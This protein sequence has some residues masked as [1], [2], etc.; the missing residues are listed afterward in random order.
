MHSSILELIDPLRGGKGYVQ[1]HVDSI[2]TLLH[3][4]P[5]E[6]QATIPQIL[7]TTLIDSLTKALNLLLRPQNPS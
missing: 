3:I 5:C 2:V 6:I 4:T 7:K 1:A